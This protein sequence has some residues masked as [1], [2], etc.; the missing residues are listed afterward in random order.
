M[1][2]SE[3]FLDRYLY[4]DNEQNLETKDSAFVSADSTEADPTPIASGGAA[5]DINTS[6]VTING[7]QLTPGTYPVTVLD[8]S[9]W[10]WTQSSVFSVT[11]TNQ[12]NWLGGTFNS[13]DGTSYT[14]AAGNTGAMTQKTYIYLDLL[15]SPTTYQYTTV[16]GDAVGAGKVLIAIAE[17][18]AVNAS[19][20]TIQGNQITGDNILANTIDASKIVAGT[21]LANVN[22]SVGSGDNIFKA[23]AN[24]IYLGNAD[25]DL[26]PFSVDMSGHAKVSSLARDDFHWFTVFESV[27]GYSKTMDGTGTIV[28]SV[29]GLFITTGLVTDEDSEIKK[30]IGNVQSWDQ[31]SKFKCEVQIPSNS[32]QEIYIVVGKANSVS[33]I[34]DHYGFYIHGNDIYSTVANGTNNYQEALTTFSA[35]EVVVLEAALNVATGL[36]SFYINDA[37]VFTS[38][39]DG[40]PTGPGT[41]ALYINVRDKNDETRTLLVS[42]W[43]F[44]Q[45]ND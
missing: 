45:A 31:D 39:G 18:G 7:G 41:N 29:Y 17:N 32:D 1:T 28:A 27:D 40:T 24:G 6:N 13:A 15:V 34:T 4:R 44:W 33:N 2:L 11:G 9:N 30:N 5:Q 10:G 26:A 37:L 38:D 42:W 21:L 22:I 3:L 19:F 43:D 16:S 23:D 20:N 8:V 35:G 12:V 25:F 14:I 36:V